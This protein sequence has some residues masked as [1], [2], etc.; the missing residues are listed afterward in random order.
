M[1]KSSKPFEN[2]FPSLDLH[3]ETKEYAIFE[4]SNFIDENYKLNNKNII[5]IHGKG[6]GILRNA[7]QETLKYKK[8]V[9]SYSLDFFNTGIT[10]VKLFDNK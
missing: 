9:K 5:I 6:E 2:Y 8:N 10:R 7:V 4:T 3:G 1:K